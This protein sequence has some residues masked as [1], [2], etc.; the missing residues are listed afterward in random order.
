MN[1]LTA[2]ASNGDSQFILV[3]TTQGTFDAFTWTKADA[4]DNATISLTMA[5]SDELALV[6]I[7]EDGTTEF[8]DGTFVVS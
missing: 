5:A 6:Q 7:T 3:N 2:S 8:A 4:M 1:A